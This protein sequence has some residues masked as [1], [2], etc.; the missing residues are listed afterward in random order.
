MPPTKVDPGASPEI[1]DRTADPAPALASLSIVVPVY[2]SEQSLPLLLARLDGIKRLAHRFEVV[3]VNDG[4][5]DGS[6]KVLEEEA[7]NY[8]WMRV[9]HLMRNYGQ[10]NA[11]LCGIRSATGDVVVT[12]DDDLQNPPEEIP[13]LL[14]KLQ[15]GYD[16]VYG[17]PEQESHGFLRDLASRITKISLQQAMGAETARRISSFRAFRLPLRKAFEDYRGAFVSIDVL[18]SWST[19]KFAAVPVPNPPRVLGRSNYTVG[20]LIAHAMNMMTGFS[21]L[22][23]RVASLVGFTIALS[24]FSLMALVVG[25][26]FIKGASVPGF[27]FLASVI[28]I[29]AGTQLFALGIIGEYL[30]RMHFRLLDRPSYA[31]RSTN[32]FETSSAVCAGGG[33]AADWKS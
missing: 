31:I 24:G 21:T 12:L 29:F 25:R 28:S 19:T 20:K 7:R 15:D 30:G 11:L 26:Y 4:S 10:H 2:N 22:P 17:F 1:C 14:A 5:R 3:L 13:K 18:L 32:G 16:M 23:L 33:M 6:H 9:I 8:R 27:T